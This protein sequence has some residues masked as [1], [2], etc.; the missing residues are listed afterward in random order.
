M[1]EPSARHPELS[2]KEAHE[3]NGQR[4][5]APH[6]AFGLERHRPQAVITLLEDGRWHPIAE[7]VAA[8]G[9]SREGV[10]HVV[11]QLG[12]ERRGASVRLIL[13]PPSP[14]LQSTR[15]AARPLRPLIVREAV[16][17]PAR[18]S[19][20]KAIEADRAGLPS[21]RRSLDHV[22]ATPETVARRVGFLDTH[23]D[24][25]GAT[26]VCLGDNDLTSLAVARQASS[27]RVIV[28]DIDER[29]LGHIDRV[30]RAQNLRIELYSA[31]LRLGLP[32]SVQGR[33]NIV[34]TDPPYTT[35]GVSLFADRAVG[36][37]DR[38]W[39][40]VV[41]CHGYGEGNPAAGERVQEALSRLHLLI[42]ALIPG[43]NSY[44]GAQAIG[45]RSDLYIL[46]PTTR[47][48]RRIDR[49][50]PRVTDARVYS[51]G[52]SSEE[53]SVAELPTVVINT[54]LNAAA[55]LG[56]A[57]PRIIGD[58]WPANL[59]TEPSLSAFLFSPTKVRTLVPNATPVILSLAPSFGSS[60]RRTLL[61]GVWR[62]LVVVVSRE[63]VSREEIENGGTSHDLL[64]SA[65]NIK[66]LDPG[67]ENN[68]VLVVQ[69][70][71]APTDDLLFVL[72]YLVAHPEATVTNAWR[73]GLI[74][75]AHLRGRDLTK[76]EAR[77]LVEAT[78]SL[79]L[80][81]PARLADLPACRINQLVAGVR[82]TLSGAGQL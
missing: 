64:R 81:A 62:P 20:V 21:S 52:V 73:E 46:R 3:G 49:G 35:R 13:S 72:R 28:V 22:R 4:R 59:V 11:S 82:S 75:C 7:L 44:Q 61:H 63:A 43:F 24:L 33:A 74:A 58:G 32:R 65:T 80:F 40:R 12:A 70:S 34:L 60:L 78:G 79:D 25:D 76:N 53:S 10:L 1:R 31:D 5:L 30:A 50:A 41:L 55:A 57:A 69:P 29:I 6:D 47:A 8:T 45:S 67:D 16:S 42:E 15:A 66:V 23:Y 68:A 17:G 39:G 38:Q 2:S 14:S 19:A 51:R 48:W 36:C 9:V 56:P 54:A 18:T 77:T 71:E 37:L 27:A 26:I